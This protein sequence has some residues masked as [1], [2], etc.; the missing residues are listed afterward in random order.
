[1]HYVY[2]LAGRQRGTLYIGMTNDLLCRVWE[3]KVKAISGFTA[4]YGV[5]HLVW[6]EPHDTLE[7]ALLREKQIKG[8]NAPGK[9]S[10][11][12]SIIHNGSISTPACRPDGVIGVG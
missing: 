1:M 2:L 8:E 3:H 9:F 6:Y 7:S 11:S 10:F 5:D 12:K 4:Q